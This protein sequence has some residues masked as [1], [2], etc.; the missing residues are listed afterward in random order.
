MGVDL[1]PAFELIDRLIEK[2]IQEQNIPGVA[3]AVTDRERLLHA[4]YQGYSDVAGKRPV[5]SDTLFQIGS[6]SK[7]FTSVAL[8]QLQEKGMVD[9]HR[10]VNDYVPWFQVKSKYG[11]I[12]LHHLMTHTAGI[13]MG[14]EETL[15]VVSEILALADTETSAPP[16][17]FFHYSNS[18]YKL[19]GLVLEAVT[20]RS[21]GEVVKDGI[22]AP[23]GM[24]STWTTVVNDLRARTAVGYVPFYDDRPI[25]PAGQFAPAPWIESDTAD[26]SISSTAEDMSKYV[27]MLSNKG[28]GP[29]GSVVSS[30]SFQKLSQKAIRMEEGV[31]N[32]YYGYGLAVT[33]TEGRA[34]IGHT[35]G[36]VG[37]IS[38]ISIDIEA[39]IG[40]LALINANLEV[41]N[42][43]RDAMRVLR[44][45]LTGRP[46]PEL[47]S[48]DMLGVENPDDYVG[49]FVSASRTLEVF[50]DGNRVSLRLQGK[51]LNMHPR[52][53]ESLYVDHPELRMFRMIFA[54]HEGKV[55]G[56]SYG[57]EWFDK[58]GAP[59][60]EVPAHPAEWEGFVGHYRSHNPWLSNFRIVLRRGS[61]YLVHPSGEETLMVPLAGRT[62]RVGKNAQSPERIQFEGI[63]NSK[64]TEAVLSGM[65][66][67]RAPTP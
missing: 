19:L 45:A 46:L 40:I 9:L 24:T 42:I 4:S 53:K 36:M 12:T 30:E 58:E 56:V 34:L 64:A 31:P 35:G 15:A 37:Y 49:R 41:Q 43:V 39:G 25:P 62:F 10:P 38:E 8:L 57:A 26:G 51:T 67:Y 20:G 66:Y 18:G 48:F 44:A 27:R 59:T 14:T 11:P 5:V 7:S 2:R 63:L 47:S 21:A 29:R 52:G 23:L 13:I 16:G 54:K 1:S 55:I 6:I 65:S 33:E 32:E 22:V 17:E 60:V 28:M 3:F 50:K 61:L